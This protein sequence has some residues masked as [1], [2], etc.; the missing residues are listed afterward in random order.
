MRRGTA[1]GEEGY[2]T[3]QKE[4]QEEEGHEKKDGERL[5]ALDSTVGGYGD[6][7]VDVKVIQQRKKG[8]GRGKGIRT[9]VRLLE[10][11]SSGAR[12]FNNSNY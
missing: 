5:V 11:Y 9:F 6:H 10:L 8:R 1:E 4:N 2:S 3:C 12:R 7:K